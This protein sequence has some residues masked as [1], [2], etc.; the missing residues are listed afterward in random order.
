MS[1]IALPFFTLG[2]DAIRADP[3]VLVEEDREVLIDDPWIADWDNARDLRIRRRLSVDLDVASSQL[4]ID[5]GNL[6]LVLLVRIGTGAGSMPRTISPVARRSIH[7]GSGEILLDERVAGPT[8]S[9]RLLAE[10]LILLDEPAV[11]AH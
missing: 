9:Q 1:R 3:W 7:Q 10:T 4:Q 6:A 2:N 5:V 11:G 8:L